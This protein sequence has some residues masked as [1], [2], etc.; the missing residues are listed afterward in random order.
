MATEPSGGSGRFHRGTRERGE[1]GGPAEERAAYGAIRLR[2][3]HSSPLSLPSRRGGRNGG[4]EAA[5][6]SGDT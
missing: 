5:G 4:T 6:S 1:P 2:G 3:R